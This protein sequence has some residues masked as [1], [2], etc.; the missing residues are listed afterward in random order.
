MFFE[1]F[2]Q[3]E[4]KNN[5]LWHEKKF[6]LTKIHHKQFYHQYWLAA[7]AEFHNMLSILESL[8]TTVFFL[9]D[10]FFEVKAVSLK[11]SDLIY[12]FGLN[13]GWA[14]FLT[15]KPFPKIA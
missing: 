15:R 5:L 14:T 11:F 2:F 6:T 12:F 13:Q 7:T 4:F 10:W 3:L 1:F 9:L 8:I